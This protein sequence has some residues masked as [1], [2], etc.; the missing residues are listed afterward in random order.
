MLLSAKDTRFTELVKLS[1]LMVIWFEAQ[2]NFYYCPS[3]LKK[4]L[5]IQRWSKVT[6]KQSSRFVVLNP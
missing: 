1:L 6:Q 4:Q 5:S 2:A 3:C